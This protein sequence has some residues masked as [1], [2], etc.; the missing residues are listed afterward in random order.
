MRIK[1][2]PSLSKKRTELLC[3][4]VP[5]GAGK[6]LGLPGYDSKTASSVS[7]SIKDNGGKTGNLTV[8][9]ISGKEP[10]RRIL[11]AG[12]GKKEKMTNDTIRCVSGKIALKARELRLKEFT[13]VA[14]PGFVSEVA[15]SVSQIVEGVKKIGRAHV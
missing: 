9:P 5:E 14:P 6:V 8:I 2:E 10:A 1:I 3:G 4:F 7:Q 11:L 13:V 15:S 12:I